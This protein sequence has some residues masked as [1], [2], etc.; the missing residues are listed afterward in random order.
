MTPPGVSTTSGGGEGGAEDAGESAGGCSGRA[1]MGLRHP[2]KKVQKSTRK[3]RKGGENARFSRFFFA[4]LP[5]NRVFDP[6]KPQK[7]AKS[8]Q[9][10]RSYGSEK[11]KKN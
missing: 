5:D 1:A 11:T 7:L 8:E 10:L 4:D 2:G 6:R 9:H 3:Q